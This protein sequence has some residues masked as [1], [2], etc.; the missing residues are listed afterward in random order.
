MEQFSRL[1]FF[2][3]NF[4][5]SATIRVYR[6]T[7]AAAEAIQGCSTKAICVFVIP[8]INIDNFWGGRTLNS[9]NWATGK[10][11]LTPERSVK[12]TNHI[13]C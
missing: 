8:W 7:P 3:L 13:R 2:L 10:N 6:K 5:N 4:H 9:V 1:M 12:D 11:K